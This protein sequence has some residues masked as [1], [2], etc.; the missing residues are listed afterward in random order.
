MATPP[1][2]ITEIMYHPA[3]DPVGT[4]AG[5]Q[6]EFIE[7]KNVGTNTL[8]L[9]GIRFTNGIEFAFTAAG[10]VTNLGPGQYLVLVS[11]PEAFLSRYPWVTNIAGQ[12][13]N[14]LNIPGQQIYLEGP[15]KEPILN[16]T[17]GNQWYP[18]TDGAGFSL[19]IRNEHAPFQT[20]SNASNWRA[21]ANPGGSPGQ[22]DPA[23]P[24]IPPVLINEA[25]SHPGAHADDTIELYNPT[26]APANIGGWF[27]TDNPKHPAKY[28]IAPGTVIPAAGYALFYKSQFDSNGS[29]SFGLSSLGDGAH[30]FS[31]DGANLTGYGQGFQFGAQLKGVTFGRYVTSDRRE[32]FVAQK[33]N[34]LGSA[35]A[36]PKIGP[37]VINEIMYSPPPF[38]LAPD[39]LDEYVEL[40]NFSGQPAPLFDPLYPTN[41]WQLQGAVQ[42]VFPPGISMAAWSFL[43]VVGFDPIQDPVRLSWFRQRFGIDANTPVFGPYQG[44]LVNEDLGVALY[45]PGSPVT[46]PS[47]LAG[48]VP[49]VLVEEVHYSSLPPWP[50]GAQAS[51][52]S[53]QRLASIAFADDPANWEAA[54]PT[55]G[56]I[57]EGAYIPD[58]DHTGLPDESEMLAG[59]DP[60]DPKDVPRFDR[61]SIRDACCVLEFTT[62]AGRTYSVEGLD[63]LARTNAWTLLWE[64][65]A[66]ADGSM[67]VV[68][69]LTV[70]G[71]LYRLR[72]ADN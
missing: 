67:R 17:F 59:A 33:A 13:T 64:E 56:A 11:N 37:V 5:D 50:G 3:P 21:S 43:L 41:T 51:G 6:F 18:A 46:S 32:H 19:V 15:F 27:L 26:T 16:F 71:R 20:W 61:V 60:L 36:G 14:T 44:D 47:A 58:T 25:L 28:C 70:G 57:N 29:N 12:Y 38:G 63:S 54:R 48:S 66:A 45:Q 42:F 2:A 65:S 31:G 23:P 1:L 30:V 68:D 9:T 39:T 53:L 40:R 62:R 52:K 72:V 35:N 22:A 49:Q 55:P 24:A 4:N 10:P 7:L 8:A 34:T 69:P